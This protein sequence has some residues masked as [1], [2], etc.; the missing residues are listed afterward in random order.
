MSSFFS[1]KSAASSSHSLAAA[2]VGPPTHEIFTEPPEGV[3]PTKKW[4]YDDAQLKQIE[5]LKAYTATLLLPESDSYHAW[6]KRFL[7]DPGTHPRYM[8][9]AKW[10]MDDARRRIKGTL[11]WRREYKPDL[12]KPDEVSVEAE[13]G[14]IIIT[15]FDA[16]ARPIIYMRPGRENT[17]TSPRQIKHLIFCLERAIDFC[18]PGQEQVAIIV[19]YKSATSQSNPSVGTARKVLHILQNHYVERLGRGLVVNMP[20]WINAFFS[21]ITPIMDPIT[22]DKIR[23]NPKLPELVPVAQLD[24]EFGGEYNFEFDHKV[25]WK[26][27]VEFCHL[28]SDGGRLDANG[29][30]AVP[31]LGNGAK[32]AFERLVPA[33][34]AIATGQVTKADEGGAAAAAPSAGSAAPKSHAQEFAQQHRESQ[35]GGLSVGAGAGVAEA[36][37]KSDG[38]SVGAD[39]DAMPNGDA[40]D[41]TTN[42]VAGLAINDNVTATANADAAP[43]PEPPT[44]LTKPGPPV[45]E[46]VFDHPPSKDEIKAALAHAEA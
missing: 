38:A 46:A 16:S 34:G 4:E 1:R 40:V 45:S 41:E 8:R 37:H 33:P 15:G 43:V 42:G 17:E 32:A 18:P 3:V 25:Y 2:N 12:I 23:F 30:P 13:T 39:V 14:K 44:V 6:E 24:K 26:T 31:P 28:A 20:W 5:E 11:E 22:R 29:Q 36:E 19:D 27:L 9:A 7:A 35:V 10:K 21:A